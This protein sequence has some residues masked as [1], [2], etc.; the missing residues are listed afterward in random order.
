MLSR[1]N[2]ASVL[3]VDRPRYT[4]GSIAVI[5][6]SLCL[7]S[8]II[9][10]HTDDDH[11]EVPCDAHVCINPHSVSLVSEEVY[12]ILCKFVST[13]L[14]KVLASTKLVSGVDLI[15]AMLCCR[16][17][18]IND[19]NVRGGAKGMIK[20]LW[21]RLT[22][23]RVHQDYDKIRGIVELISHRSHSG[24]ARALY[25]VTSA[26]PVKVSAMPMPKAGE[27]SQL[28]S[29]RGPV[30]LDTQMQA[31]LESFNH[32]NCHHTP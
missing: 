14:R 4:P 31:V 7:S 30:V 16:S 22:I 32:I 29:V 24:Y 10:I 5:V 9:K 27:Y 1:M 15:V 12:A 3:D 25:P 19:S 13:R 18:G 6:S 8:V 17:Y 28:V 23:M 26:E 11:I 21:S 20:T 2:C